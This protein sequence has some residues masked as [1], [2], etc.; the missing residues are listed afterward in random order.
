VLAQ[1]IVWWAIAQQT[2]TARH[3]Q[4]C[5]LINFLVAFQNKETGL[6]TVIAKH[7]IP[8]RHVMPLCIVLGKCGLLF[9]NEFFF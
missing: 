5:D 4:Q 7:R 9:D 2:S 8:K 1:Q 6:E 3:R